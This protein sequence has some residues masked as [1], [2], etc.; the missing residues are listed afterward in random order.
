MAYEVL[1]TADAVVDLED[2]HAWIRKSDGAGRANAVLQ[3]IEAAFQAL[4][5][6]PHRGVWPAELAELGIRQ[7]RE[8]F[9]KPYRIVYQVMEQ[10]V[11][12]MLIADGRRD[13]QSLLQRRLL[14]G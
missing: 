10:H 9:F 14:L 11:Y 6:H 12:V 13:M 7:Y 2:L 4:S 1:L 3:K 8:I 5:E